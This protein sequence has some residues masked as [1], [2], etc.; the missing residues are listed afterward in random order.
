MKLRMASESTLSLQEMYGHPFGKNTVKVLK[1]QLRLKKMASKS[2]LLKDCALYT[3]LAVS[4]YQ[5]LQTSPSL[6]VSTI[7]NQVEQNSDMV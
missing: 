4:V 2:K 5:L 1:T 6:Q 7:F 3:R